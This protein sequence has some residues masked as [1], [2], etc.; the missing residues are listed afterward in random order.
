MGAQKVVL[1]QMSV[2][3][4]TARRR[5]SP[6]SR[7]EPSAMLAAKLRALR[8]R[9]ILFAVLAGL[10]MVIAV[11][12]ELLALAMFFDWW[13]DLPWGIR[14]LSLIAQVGIL[15]F[16]LLRMVMRPLISRPD[17]DELALIVER[18]RP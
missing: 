15:A 1:P 10:G 18:A 13:L 4:E 8:R 12:V 17:D 11:N 2:N 7:V 9:H 6:E 3:V 14:L 5:P 16:I